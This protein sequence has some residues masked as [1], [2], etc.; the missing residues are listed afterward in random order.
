MNQA[1]GQTPETPSSLF[2]V[3]FAVEIGRWTY[4]AGWCGNRVSD[5]GATVGEQTCETC[6]E[7]YP[8]PDVAAIYGEQ[9]PKDAG[10]ILSILRGDTEGEVIL[11]WTRP[12]G[13][14]QTGI[15]LLDD[16]PDNFMQSLKPIL[17]RQVA[18][19]EIGSPD[20]IAH[21]L[22]LP[23]GEEED[24]EIR[25]AV[26]GL[27][28]HPESGTFIHGWI[29]GDEDVAIVLLEKDGTFHALQD[30]YRFPRPD[31]AANFD[32][33][34]AQVSRAG[35]VA[36]LENRVSGPGM[37][38][39]MSGTAT[40]TLTKTP[41]PRLLPAAP[42]AAAK[43]LLGVE[44][45][46]PDLVTR[47][48]RVDWPILAPLIAQE[49]AGW[50]AEEVVGAD[51][52]P[53]PDS[54]EVSLI[55]PLYG[56]YDFVEHQLME[57][58]RD[59]YLRDR[60]EVVYVVDDPTIKDGFAGSCGELYQLY[61][62]PFRWVWGGVNR[63]FSGANNLGASQAR[64]PRLL[65][66][67]SDVFP[68]QP[69]W[70]EQMVT[71][72]DSHPTLGVVVP[73]L[74]FANGGI[75]HCGMI[76]KRLDSLG[77]WINHHPN[78]GLDPAFDP[79]KELEAVELATGACMLVR[80]EEF[81]RLGGWNTGYLIGDYEDSDLCFS[82]RAAGLDIGYLPTVSLVHLERQSFSQ[83]GADSFKLRVTIANSVRHSSRWPQFLQN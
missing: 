77:I 44:T 53:Q 75:Q 18:G 8:R 83:I 10:F 82:Y 54:P 16:L 31:L 65:F 40:L 79:R 45:P 42:K 49:Q 36:R 55:I 68:Q 64:A 56:R 29:L 52:G 72:L 20:W 15:T 19:F 23:S 37:L 67:N 5:I 4:V 17:E 81:E 26:D 61:G 28:S 60:V 30:M 27:F 7:R 74:L 6:V 12:D 71:A 69:R 34:Q 9:I 59:P 24:I 11:H 80:R 51:L 58:S 21:Q 66:M 46:L 22:F 35:F 1:A 41:K 33:G 32:A 63:G 2:F 39:A 78:L 43:I 62:F 57:F 13:V 14:D 70:L 73:R 76:S 47:L 38:L 48:S 50:A 25:G 3:D